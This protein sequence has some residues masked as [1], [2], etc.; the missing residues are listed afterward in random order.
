MLFHMKQADDC[1][2]FS[3]K[4]TKSILECRLPE[5]CLALKG[6]KSWPGNSQLFQVVWLKRFFFLLRITHLL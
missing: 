4:I 3:E 1:L 5:I 2:I 6:L